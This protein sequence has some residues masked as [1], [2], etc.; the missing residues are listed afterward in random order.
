M[1]PIHKHKQPAS[2][3]SFLGQISAGLRSGPRTHLSACSSRKTPLSPPHSLAAHGLLCW[4]LAHSHAHHILQCNIPQGP[5]SG[6]CRQGSYWGED[7][8]HYN[9][10]YYNVAPEAAEFMKRVILPRG[11][12]R[13]KSN[14]T[15]EKSPRRESASRHLSGSQGLRSPRA[16]EDSVTSPTRLTSWNHSSAQRTPLWTKSPPLAG[17]HSGCSAAPAQ[18]QKMRH[19]PHSASRKARRSCVH[20]AATHCLLPSSPSLSTTTRTLWSL[21]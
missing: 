1:S 19:T 4:G 16:H 6:H 17:S 13:P 15:T 12:Q 5:P 7:S 3:G 10:H 8:S 14:S 20:R 18:V 11:S 2:L 9:T 21:L